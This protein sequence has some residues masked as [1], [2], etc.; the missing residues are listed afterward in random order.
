M[1]KGQR[2]LVRREA[3]VL[4]CQRNASCVC[5]RCVRDLAKEVCARLRHGGGSQSLD[6]HF[7]QT[8][9][10]QAGP[11]GSR[12]ADAVL[13]R[14]ACLRRAGCECKRCRADQGALG[15]AAAADGQFGCGL[16]R[17]SFVAMQAQRARCAPAT[18][19]APPHLSSSPRGAQGPTPSIHDA[20]AAGDESEA[21]LHSAAPNKAMQCLRHKQFQCEPR[22]RSPGLPSPHLRLAPSPRP[23]PPRSSPIPRRCRLREGRLRPPVPESPPPPVS[24]A[25]P[26]SLSWP[27]PAAKADALPRPP[28]H[29]PSLRRPPVV[30]PRPLRLPLAVATKK[31]PLS[32]ASPPSPPRPLH[33]SH[34]AATASDDGADD[35]E[36][37]PF[38]VLLNLPSAHVPF[39]DG[40]PT[41]DEA[42]ETPFTVLPFI[43]GTTTG[44]TPP[45][46]P[47][48]VLPDLTRRAPISPSPPALPSSGEWAPP[49]PSGIPS[50]GEWAQ[51]SPSGIPSSGEWAPPSPSGI[52]SSGEWAQ[53]SP[54]GIPSSSEL[55]PPSP[56]GIPSSS[57]W[58]PPSPS[59]IPSS[60][61]WAPPSPSGIPSSGEWFSGL[62][63]AEALGV[64]QGAKACAVQLQNVTSPRRAGVR[65]VGYAWAGART[66]GFSRDR[67][68]TKLRP[69]GG[70]QRIS[71]LCSGSMA[72]WPK[73]SS[74]PPAAVVTS[75]PGGDESPVFT[76][77]FKA[78][79]VRSPRS[80][81]GSRPLPF[82][83]LAAAAGLPQLPR[84]GS[85]PPCMTEFCVRKEPIPAE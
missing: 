47:N 54:S 56:S 55:A 11:P 45:D 80:Q 84:S 72:R 15:G 44:G 78:A 63:L 24:R 6:S 46:L 83:G 35:A 38:T 82:S 34:G 23:T 70:R 33:A 53:P 7:S 58:A 61:E 28:P 32:P 85:A 66:V 81:G 31:P 37:T 18:W 39:T 68:K 43:D 19:P 10:L 20:D 14:D 3:A 5:P 64:E 50:S 75:A 36:E 9:A 73:H 48:L 21:P 26:V 74:L 71:A 17:P 8:A 29:F 57:E 67:P 69:G 4:G 2:P 51:P 25:Q 40:T 1:E 76:P 65:D 60:G 79:P 77:V 41:A 16:G 27:S 22:A 52:P 12:S 30:S 13:E 42:E 59:G 62:P 49:S